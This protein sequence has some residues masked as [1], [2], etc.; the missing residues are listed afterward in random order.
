MNL[1]TGDYPVHGKVANVPSVTAYALLP[2][3]F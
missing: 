3:A 1:K 2:M